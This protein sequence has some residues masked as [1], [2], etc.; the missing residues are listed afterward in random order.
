MPV[1]HLNHSLNFLKLE[2]IYEMKLST[3]LHQLYNYKLPDIFWQYFANIN[4]IHDFLIKNNIVLLIFN[5]KL[6]LIEKYS[7]I[8]SIIAANRIVGL[9]ICIKNLNIFDHSY[10][11]FGELKKAVIISSKVFKS[12]SIK[13]LRKNT[14]TQYLRQTKDKQKNVTISLTL[15]NYYIKIKHT[16]KVTTKKEKEIM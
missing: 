15:R 7:N 6:L 12:C 5:F 8:Q 10:G 9:N 11:L 3:L 14:I 4:T 13:R 2:D 1:S 16:K